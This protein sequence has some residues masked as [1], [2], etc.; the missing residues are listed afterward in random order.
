MP[1][2]FQ[3]VIPTQRHAFCLFNLHLQSINI[4]YTLRTRNTYW[5]QLAISLWHKL[6]Q[7]MAASNCL[8]HKL[9]S[10]SGSSF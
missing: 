8:W 5:G 4:S 1:T 9:T 10:K 6:G 7:C 3:A 2:P